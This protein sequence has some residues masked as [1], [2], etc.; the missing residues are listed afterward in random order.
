VIYLASPYSGTEE[1]QEARFLAAECFVADM[2]PFSVE[3]IFS[4]IVFCHEMA[5]RH[6]LPGDANF[7]AAMNM[8]YMRAASK[9]WVLKLPGWEES[10]GVQ[11]E[12]RWAHVERKPLMYVE[13]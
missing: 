6:N 8:D 5:K 10:I 7:W 4:P 12:I 11:D 13:P 1:E 2:L 9:I 3:A